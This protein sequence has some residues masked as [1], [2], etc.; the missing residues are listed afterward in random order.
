[1]CG[2]A[3]YLSLRPPGDGVLEAMTTTLAHRGPDA[4][5]FYRDRHEHWSVG[6]GHRRLSV[7]DLE[8]SR[9]PMA[10]ADERHVVS[11][12]GEIYNFQTL[13]AELEAQGRT[14]RTR[15]DTEVLLQGYAHWG[16]A[17]VERLQG[18]FAFAIWDRLT[19]SLFLARDQL[20]VKPL[21]F[22]WDGQH[23]V[24]GSEI[25]AL[26][27]S[28]VV[29]H[30]VDLDALGLYLESQFIPGP[31]TIHRAI[32]KLAPGEALRIRGGQLESWRYWQPHYRP[33]ADFEESEALAQLEVELRKSVESMMVADVP[34]GS[35]LSGGID[36]SL[37]SALMTDIGGRPINT[38]HIGFVGRDAQSEHE[39]ADIVARHIGAHHHVLMMEGKE[40]VEAFDDFGR[41]FDE[42]YGDP[43]AVP[44][45]L[46]A[47]MA[48]RQVTVALTGEGADELFSGYGNYLRHEAVQRWAKPL[49]GRW[50][51]LPPL[52]RM[53]PARL[54]K[55]RG[56]KAI[57]T[58][59]SRR[60]VTVPHVFD[61]LLKPGLFSAGLLAGQTREMADFAQPFYEECDT[62]YEIERAMYVDLRLWLPDDLMVKMDR[63]TMAHSLEA[64]V[65]FLDHRFVEFCARLHPR[66]KQN[67]PT[68][69]YLLKQLAMR[70]L[71]GTI[72]HRSKQGFM[73]P[74]ADWIAGQLGDRVRGA[75]T[76]LDRRGLFQPG[77]LD[78]LL[79][80]HQSGGARHGGRLWVLLMLENWFEHHAADWRLG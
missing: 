59:P 38:F 7:I 42:P 52:V 44:T 72:V 61:H 15:G 8:A 23:F 31:L 55:D 19:G 9:Q 18:M 62:A 13:R 5:G 11:F 37:V 12:N 60:Y 2:I 70:Y 78:K 74:L 48:R 63:A 65:P 27:A 80:D 36:S 73:P 66:F 10:T 43:A 46:L 47:Q 45:L 30:D 32:R 67:G 41:V 57:T 53:L 68:T 77:V 50:S 56:L 64:R 33:K 14:F 3:G 28:G 1:M 40:I 34:L 29:S 75:L 76:S 51:P 26:L 71:P 4:D 6:L 49:T 69:K 39:K 24:F 35:F 79:A 20:G 22:A 25:K 17:V 21:H 54:R 58:P 16:E